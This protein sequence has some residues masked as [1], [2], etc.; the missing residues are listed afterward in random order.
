M[1]LTISVLAEEHCASTSKIRGS[2]PGQPEKTVKGGT[3]V[4]GGSTV[5]SK[6]LQQS[7]RTHLRP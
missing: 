2:I 6:I 3:T 7:F 1:S 5:L 4:S